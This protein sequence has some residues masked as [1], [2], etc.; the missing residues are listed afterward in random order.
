M[1]PR[2]RLAGTCASLREDL[3]KAAGGM[4]N[5]SRNK[6]QDKDTDM[7]RQ[8]VRVACDAVS[9]EEIRIHISQDSND[10]RRMDES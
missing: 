8:V 3:R 1:A 10:G 5:G 2:Q 9:K 4:R 7:V 6:Y